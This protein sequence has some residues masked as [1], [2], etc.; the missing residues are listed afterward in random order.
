[1]RR[2]ENRSRGRKI[3]RRTANRVNNRTLKIG[4]G[5]FRL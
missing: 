2:R 5:G 4:R 1:M 3:F